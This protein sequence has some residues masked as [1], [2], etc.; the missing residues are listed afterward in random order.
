M[1]GRPPAAR[2]GDRGVVLLK[3]QSP[4]TASSQSG[5]GIFSGAAHKKDVKVS[6]KK[7]K[8]YLLEFKWDAT[9]KWSLADNKAGLF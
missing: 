8:C 9:K 3:Y 7:T 5:L 1:T 2:R 4:S 6:V